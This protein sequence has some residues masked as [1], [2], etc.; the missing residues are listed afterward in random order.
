MRIAQITKYFH[1][2]T[3]GIESH[4]LGISKGLVERGHEVI[5]YT[6][7]DPKDANAEELDGMTIKRFPVLFTLF[8][9]PFTP[10]L[11]FKLLSD[12]YD[13]IHVHLPDPANSIFAWITSMVKKKPLYVTYHADIIKEKWYHKPFTFTYSIFL[14]QILKKAKRIIATTPNYV[15]ESQIPKKYRDKISIVPNF[16]DINRFT[17]LIYGRRIRQQH[18]ID[19]KRKVVYF[20]GRLVPYKGVDYLIKAYAEVKKAV[21]DSTLIITG[22]G[23][24]ESELR[25]LAADLKV[26]DVIFVQVSEED[27]PEYYAAC[28][29]FV[30]PSVTRAEAF[31]IALAEAMACGKAVITTNISGMPYVVG[32]AGLTVPPKDEKALATAI[33]KLLKDDNLRKELGSKARERVE[34]EFNQDY[35]TEKILGIYKSK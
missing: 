16:V 4:V 13:L 31:G 11:F 7:N 30:L 9:G 27:I 32:E 6:S 21:P 18:N 3:G 2:H 19:E 28:D 12:D 35:V 34:E 10:T 33:I 23:P 24:L 1:P 5:I 15:T 8:N 14:G 25:R 29:L 22:R 17:P 26:E 20:L